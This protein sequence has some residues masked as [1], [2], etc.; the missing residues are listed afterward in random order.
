[1]QMIA[2]LHTHTLCATKISGNY[3]EIFNILLGELM[4]WFIRMFLLIFHHH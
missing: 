3:L 2:D 4:G 1:M